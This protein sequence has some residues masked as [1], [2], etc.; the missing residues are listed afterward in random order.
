MFLFVFLVLL[1]TILNNSFVLFCFCVVVFVTRLSGLLVCILWSFFLF[2]FFVVLFWLC[3][4]CFSFLSKKTPKKPDTAKTQES[5]NAEKTDKQNS[6]SAVVFTNSIFN[7]F[8]VGLKISFLAENTIKFCG[9]GTFS[10]WKNGRKL[11]KLLSWT[12]VQ[13]WVENLSNYV[14]QH[15][16]TDFQRK[17][18]SFSFFWKISFFLQKEEDFWKTQKQLKI[19]IF[20][21]IFNSKKGNFWTEFQFYS[22]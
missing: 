6:V 13:G 19:V 16:W 5:K 7:F 3:L 21:Q 12:S 10:K 17:N 15:N 1:V 2:C 18:G 22:I 14:A 4:F 11:T 9:F 8:G 20:G